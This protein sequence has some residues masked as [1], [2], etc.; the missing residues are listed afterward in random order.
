MA[1]PPWPPIRHQETARDELPD[2]RQPELL[3][4]RLA[5]T[6]AGEPMMAPGQ[7]LLGFMAEQDI[8]DMGRAEA[9]AA[10]RDGR[11][12]DPRLGRAVGARRL[13]KAVVAIAARRGAFAEIAKQDLTA[14]LRRL[15]I[16]DQRIEPAM[17]APFVL[18]RAR[19]L[20]R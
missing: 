17:R 1:R 6:E 3:L 10:L 16:A 14:A 18:R 7:H 15:A 4:V 12:D 2:Q 19:P 13:V 5:G 20:R 8:D 9:L 11:E